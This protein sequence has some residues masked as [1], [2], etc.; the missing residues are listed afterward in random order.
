MKKYLLLILPAFL[1]TACTVQQPI[2]RTLAQNNADYKV[3]YLFQQDGCKI[4][5]FYDRGYYVYF[6][7]CNGQA[8]TPMDSTH[9]GM[10]SGNTARP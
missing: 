10:S 2:S 4:Y 1:F 7:N 5:R 6:T 9:R 8:F 3:E